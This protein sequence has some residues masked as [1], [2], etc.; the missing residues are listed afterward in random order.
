VP[1]LRCYIE[2]VNKEVFRLSVLCEVRVGYEKHGVEEYWIVDPR[3]K[4]IEIYVNQS[5]KFS[6][7][8]SV[9]SGGRCASRIIGGLEIEA[10]DVFGKVEL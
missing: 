6:L 1:D 8:Q 7:I 5:G 10:K 2:T 4:T 9:D 3:L